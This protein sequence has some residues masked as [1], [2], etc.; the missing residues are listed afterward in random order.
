ACVLLYLCV[1]K[2]HE[3]SRWGGITMLIAYAIYFVYLML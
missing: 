3:L 1:F 2:D